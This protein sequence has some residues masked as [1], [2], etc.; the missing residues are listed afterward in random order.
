M[1]IVILVLNLLSGMWHVVFVLYI[2]RYLKLGVPVYCALA[3][4]GALGGLL[5]AVDALI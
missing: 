5:G 3:M 2:I 4:S 1:T